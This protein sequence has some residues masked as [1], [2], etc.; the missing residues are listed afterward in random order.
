M[1]IARAALIKIELMRSDM[2][3]LMSS[4]SSIECVDYKHF[5]PK[6][7]RQAIFHLGLIADRSK[8]GT[9]S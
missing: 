8:H 6:G 3:L 1:F 7:L 5:V 9:N 2:S 4:Q